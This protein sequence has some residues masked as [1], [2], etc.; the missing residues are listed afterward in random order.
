MKK[1]IASIA[2]VAAVFALSSCNQEKEPTS[3][4]LVKVAVSM[5]AEFPSEA[6]F[7]GKVVLSNKTT[8]ETI[9]AQAKAGVAEF[10]K[11]P[12]GV[13]SASASWSLTGDQL[14]GIAPELAGVNNVAINGTNDEVILSEAEKD[15]IEVKI[16]TVYAEKAPLVFSRIYNHGTLK[17]DTKAYNIDKYLE[18]FNNSDEVQYLDGLYIGEAYGSAVMVPAYSDI[19]KA[20]VVYMQRISRF[21]GSGKDYAVEPGTSFVVAMNAKNHIDSE[22]VVNTVDLSGADIEAYVEGAAGFFPADNADVPNL[23]PDIYQAGTYQAKF[24][25]G[26]ATIPVL[27][28]ASENEIASYEKVLVPGSD[29]YG[30]AFAS[31]SLA[32]PAKKV[33][34]AV[35]LMRTGFET[36]GGKHLPSAIDAGYAMINQGSLAARKIEK[37]E[38][39]RLY[40]VDSNNST[41]DFVELTNDKADGSHLKARD[42]SDSRIQPVTE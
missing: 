15:G 39:G 1:F 29:A 22:V 41:N 8:S 42:Y 35:D 9:E 36:R 2:A 26:Q 12:F 19:D 7:E 16:K 34:D 6:V 33:I 38:N 18:I 10:K 28:R 32:V 17:L 4:S 27:F 40:L 21:P 5:P 3:V 24:L 11:V 31:Y 13:W 25:A 30:A 20:E 37:S 23:I 14:A